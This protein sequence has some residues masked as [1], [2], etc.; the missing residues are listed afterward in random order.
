[1]RAIFFILAFYTFLL[2]AHAEQL[3]I[4][5]SSKETYERSVKTMVEGMSV[6]DKNIFG[7]GLLSLILKRYPAAQGAKGAEV[8]QLMAPALESAHIT[9]DGVSLDEILA[10]GR[11]SIAAKASELSSKGDRNDDSGDDSN[12]MREKVVIANAKIVKSDFG[13]NI[14][15]K[16]TNKL[17]W[18][19]SGIGV[20]YIVMSEGR[21]VPWSR[22]KFYL[23]IDG[24][25]EPNETRSIS[26]TAFISN[27]APDILT[28]SATV[29]DVAD[30]EKRQLIKATSIAGWSDDKTILKCR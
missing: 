18:A 12:C 29:L 19:I 14:K 10:A 21:K 6:E 17:N 30:S 28:V 15:L 1:M 25:I 16:V 9:M 8:F 26:T 2:T 11:E 5:G 24:G 23:S 13:Q 22:E 27:E 3:N 7:H 4:D 20:E